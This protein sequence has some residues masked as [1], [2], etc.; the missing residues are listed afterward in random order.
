[1][2]IVVVRPLSFLDGCIFSDTLSDRNRVI[3]EHPAII[4]GRFH[5]PRVERRRRTGRYYG[6][7]GISTPAHPLLL[8][9]LLHFLPA[10][11]PARLALSHRRTR[12]AAGKRN[13][14]VLRLLQV[15]ELQPRRR[16]RC[17]K[18][19]TQLLRDQPVRAGIRS[20][21]FQPCYLLNNKPN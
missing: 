14:A 18:L 19:P 4:A 9:V 1:M 5:R 8:G 21:F 3:F 12:G 2:I 15:P 13:A 20:S 7:G 11:H 17:R 10:N 16:R 6:W